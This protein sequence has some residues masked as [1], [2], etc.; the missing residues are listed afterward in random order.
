MS[1][2]VSDPEYVG[3]KQ[4]QRRHIVVSAATYERLVPIRRLVPCAIV[5]RGLIPRLRLAKTRVRQ[6][7]QLGSTTIVASI[8]MVGSKDDI[9]RRSEGSHQKARLVGTTM[10]SVGED[11]NGY[12]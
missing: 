11:E 3:V 8:A 12:R 5:T 1:S 6:I 2:K 7:D 10:K 4:R 9:A